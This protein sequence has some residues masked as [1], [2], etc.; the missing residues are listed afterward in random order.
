MVFINPE[1]IL[2][3]PNIYALADALN[4]LDGR[5]V[6]YDSTSLPIFGDEDDDIGDASG[7]FSWDDNRILKHHDWDGWLVSER[8][9]P[10]R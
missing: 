10:K 8:F 2:S 3:A 4:D 6:F 7:V 9:D 5:G 1:C